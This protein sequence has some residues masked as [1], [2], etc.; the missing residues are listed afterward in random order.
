MTTDQDTRQFVRTLKEDRQRTD[1]RLGDVETSEYNR[2]RTIHLTSFI[3]TSHS[4]A[5][6]STYTSQDIRALTSDLAKGIMVTVFIDTFSDATLLIYFSSSDDTPDQYHPRMFLKSPG[7]G[8]IDS[9][10]SQSF[11]IPLGADG[12]FKIFNTSTS[13]AAAVLTVALHGWWE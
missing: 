7:A 1:R 6:N 8:P 5:V 4:V 12:A 3:V 13:Q 2:I 9:L 10:V 11:W